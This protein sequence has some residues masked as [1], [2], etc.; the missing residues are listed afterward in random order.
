MPKKPSGYVFNDESKRWYARLTYTNEKG[1]RCN[2]RRRAENKTQAKEILR[3]LLQDLD[4]LGYKALDGTRMTFAE[5]ADFHK[6][7]YLNPAEYVNG[8]KVTGLRSYRDLRLR[9]A[10]LRDHFGSRKIRFITYGEIEYY[11]G[12]RLRTP[13]HR[14]K[15]RSIATVN[16]EL[17]LLRRVLN[18]AVRE[19]WLI[20][21]PMTPGGTMISLADESRRERILTR[22][23]ET[24]LLASC[25]GPRAH[26]RPILTI[27]L[28]TGMRRSEIFKLCWPDVDFTHKLITIQAFNT[29]TMRERRVAMTP[30]LERELRQ[31]RQAAPP[32]CTGL[33][34]GI[35][36]TVKRSFDTAKRKAGLKD[37]RF[38]D[39]RHTAATRLVQGHIPLSEVG[40]VLG[41]T[42]T[43]TTYRYVNANVDTARRAADVLAEFGNESPS[44]TD[45]ESDN[46]SDS[47]TS[48]LALLTDS[49]S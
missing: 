7:T 35:K 42:Q 34:F 5:L 29:K 20:R 43:N 8:R 12:L 17:F 22:D 36:D 39:L 4:N 26:L 27:A 48:P 11:R 31:L 32:D 6:R 45:V 41:H 30:R 14:G 2:I 19:G 1:I 10:T 21:N 44:G 37:V 18:V 23:E 47:T 16:R 38:H 28:D 49:K 15:Q 46:Q 13:T 24:E 25:V 33:V 9:L 3:E 40:R